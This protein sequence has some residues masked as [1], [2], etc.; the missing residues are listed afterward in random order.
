M[1]R[2]PYCSPRAT[3]P[4]FPPLYCS[5]QSFTFYILVS[6]T[7]KDPHSTSLAGSLRKLAVF[8]SLYIP[9]NSSLAANLVTVERCLY[10][11]DFWSG[12]IAVYV[13]NYQQTGTSFN[14]TF[15]WPASFTLPNGITLYFHTDFMEAHTNSF[16]AGWINHQSIMYPQNRITR[17]YHYYSPPLFFRGI[18]TNTL[19]VICFAGTEYRQYKQPSINHQ[20]FRLERLYL[21]PSL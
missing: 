7:M 1:G 17:S 21:L 9:L 5:N 20:I 2:H 10:E 13:S 19:T 12:F 3:Q 18:Q 11:M 8:L 4:C 6:L 15:P 14:A 16:E